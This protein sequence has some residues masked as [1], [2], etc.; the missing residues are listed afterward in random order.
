MNGLC[1]NN[2]MLDLGAST[3]V[4]SLKVLKQLG[5]KTTRPYGNVCGID[6]RK[7]KVLGVWKDVEVFL[8]YFPHI[9]ILMD[10]VVIDVPDA[11]GMLLS[12]SWSIALGSFLSMES[13]MHT[14][15]WGMGLFRYYTI[16]RKLIDT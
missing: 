10:I 4:I 15:L 11:W 8:V 9:S 1:L 7:V 12:R 14:F 16:E 6:S 2:Y 13:P 3:N 5:L